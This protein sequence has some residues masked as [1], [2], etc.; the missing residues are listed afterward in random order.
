MGGCGEGN[1]P[2]CLAGRREPATGRPLA[3]LVELLCRSI[4]DLEVGS[5]SPP[6]PGKMKC[7]RV[8]I[9]VDRLTI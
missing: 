4:V 5:A 7:V 1:K 9:I 3:L 6:L 8:E 2:R